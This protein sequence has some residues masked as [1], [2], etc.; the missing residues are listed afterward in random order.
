ML[1]MQLTMDVPRTLMIDSMQRQ[2]A[3]IPMALHF[4]CF[5]AEYRRADPITSTSTIG[6]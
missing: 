5:A 1:L 3:T 4:G 6:Q 2:R